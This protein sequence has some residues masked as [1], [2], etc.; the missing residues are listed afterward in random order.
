MAVA[1]TPTFHVV[2]SGNAGSGSVTDLTLLTPVRKQKLDSSVIVPVANSSTHLPTRNNCSCQPQS[3]IC[4]PCG[5]CRRLS[6]CHA[7]CLYSL[8]TRSCVAA[9]DMQ[10]NSVMQLLSVCYATSLARI[11]FMLRAKSARNAR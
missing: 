10:A 1:V 3:A 8:Q 2:M 7:S 11:L 4:K 5:V 6:C 9:I